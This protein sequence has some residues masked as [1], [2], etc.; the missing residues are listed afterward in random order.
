[1]SND[2]LCLQN[3]IAYVLCLFLFIFSYLS[4]SLSNMLA[5]LQSL[6]AA[7]LKEDVDNEDEELM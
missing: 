3:H 6:G 7:L 1:M 4:E 5:N 2:G